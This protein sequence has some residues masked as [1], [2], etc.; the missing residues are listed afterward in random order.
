M[1][2]MC[3]VCV[4]ITLLFTLVG[5]G[6]G[7]TS[8]PALTPE[9]AQPENPSQGT[10]LNISCDGTTLSETIANGS[11]GSSVQIT[12]NATSCGYLP[13]PASGTVL[14][15]LCDGTTE[16]VT[17]ADGNGGDSIQNNVNAPS[18]GY[19]PP[20]NT[21]P[22]SKISTSTTNFIA[23]NEYTFEG[24]ESSDSDEGDTITYRWTLDA[25]EYSQAIIKDNTAGVI[26]IRPDA[27]G[28]YTL[29]L[30]VTDKEGDNDSKSITFIPKVPKPMSL[31]N[32]TPTSAPVAVI[33]DRID[34]VRLLKQA[35]FGP[36]IES[37]ERILEIGAEAWFDEQQNKPITDWQELRTEMGIE[38][39]IT[40]ENGG[41]REL[42]RE[43]FN[44]AA[45]WREDQLRQ[46]IAY[47]L[48]QLF[49]VSTD[50]D[51]GHRDIAFTTYWN[52]LSGNAFGN[53]RTLLK[54]VTLHP[55]MGHYLNMMGN[56]KSDPQRNIRPDENFA[57]EV[58]QLFT[59]GLMELNQDGTAKQT[60]NGEYVE[61]Y[62]QTIIQNYAAALTGWYYTKPEI[63]NNGREN[64]FAFDCSVHCHPHA[65]SGTNM[66]AYQQIH[67]KTEKQLLRGYYI[68]PGQTAEEDLEIV[69]D[70]LYYHPNLAPF[71]AMHMIR[72]MVT[73]NPS[74]EYVARVAAVFNNNGEGGRGD[75]GATVKAV[76][77]DSEARSPESSGV[78][79]FGK[80]KEPLLIDTHL[81]RL[82]D[83]RLHSPESI[84]T[85]NAWG[86]TRWSPL[87]QR[88]QEPLGA[89]SVFN[90]FRPD[91]VPNGQ[92]KQMGK[93]SPEMQ[94]N[95]ETNIVR[96]I[97][98]AR[99]LRTAEIREYKIASGGGL[100]EHAA[101][102]SNFGM[103]L[104][105]WDENGFSAVIEHLDI[106]LTAGAMSSEYKEA[107]LKFETDPNYEHVFDGLDPQWD[108]K[109]S[110]LIEKHYFLIELI[111]YII[112]T[113]QFAVQQ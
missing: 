9:P 12:E 1:L 38:T 53:F 15:T 33:K 113:P 42:I 70:S 96:W 62:D 69:L 14:S 74:P 47:G 24:L 27:I 41:G 52:R 76:L 61:T 83:I 54:E 64:Y 99:W 55:T 82:F 110:D 104:Q 21:P 34:A 101:G 18:C 51:L 57:R 13:P 25:P 112:S 3:R 90:F 35:T 111:Y 93:V 59:I 19:L 17:T 87:G 50:T 78:K 103:L 56:M 20:V 44:I 67:Q 97:G 48:S 39:G 75:I 81:V 66:V 100:N 11:G 40:D 89:Q 22:K 91:Y 92:I 65:S 86:S 45:Y 30:T 79:L 31:P 71:F 60:D 23:A 105:K 88:V 6:G 16:I 98:T 108:E 73:S 102:P 49:V 37:T 10:V 46:R 94:I 95:T 2:L 58:M 107:L 84:S 72:H 80:V 26:T 106:Y 8:S 77:F 36:T 63:E 5:C 43:T 85:E 7:S 32:F 4:L 109:S 29:T 68:P 28:S